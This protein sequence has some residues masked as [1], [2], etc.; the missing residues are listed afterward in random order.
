MLKHIFIDLDDTILDFSGG[1]AKALSTTLASFGLDPTPEILQLYHV[2]NIRHWEMLERGELTRPQVLVKRFE[3]LFAELG[4]P[5]SGAEVNKTYGYNLS[6]QHD[7]LPGAKDLLNTLFGK[8]DLYLASNGNLATQQRR[9]TDANLYPWFQGVFI[10][11]EIGANKPSPEF[12]E[13][14]FS[15]IPSFH[16]E[17]AVMIG[18]SLTSDI[19]GGRD[20]GLRTIWFNPH[21]KAPA[22]DIQPDFE[23]E[24]LSQLPGLLEIL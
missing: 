24:S 16:P 1:E 20:A 5:L 19:K 4:L 7:F 17:D 3:A 6:L 8:Y 11:E 23:I 9:L 12:F 18:D 14:C 15:Q 22:A 2:I 21:H 13:K 10:S